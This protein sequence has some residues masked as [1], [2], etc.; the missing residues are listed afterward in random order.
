MKSYPERFALLLLKLLCPTRFFE[1]IEGDIIEQFEIDVEGMGK[2]K[3]KINLLW[4]TL[5]FFRPGIIIR[6]QVQFAWPNLNYFRSS[7]GQLDF[8]KANNLFGWFVFVLA[9]LTYFLTLEPTASFWDCSEFIA[10]SNKLEVP[11]PPGAPMFLLLG[12]FF[13][14][15]AFGDTTKIAYAINMMSALASAFT[16]LF[17]F[18]SIVLFGRKLIRSQ[19]FPTLSNNICNQNQ[20][21]ICSAFILHQI[22]F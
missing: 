10:T 22:P 4:N 15:F 7:P 3:A 6:N 13:S 18:W 11:H 19:I 12:R 2:R 17:L 21:A 16:I 8:N 14:L 1:T 5:N 9:L 20:P